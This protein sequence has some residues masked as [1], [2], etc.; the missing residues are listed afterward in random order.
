MICMYSI[1][2]ITDYKKL[3]AVGGRG[4]SVFYFNFY[5]A[6]GWGSERCAVSGN[7]HTH[8]TAEARSAGMM[9]KKKCSFLQ[10]HTPYHTYVYMHVGYSYISKKEKKRKKRKKSTSGSKNM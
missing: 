6:P 4:G 9:Q 5:V 7:I 3:R 1:Y 10:L 8:N 2:G